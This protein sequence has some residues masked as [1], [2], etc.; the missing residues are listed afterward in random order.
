MKKYKIITLLL[1]L[2]IPIIINAKTCERSSINIDSIELVNKTINVVEKSEPEIN[3]ETIKLDLEMYK[4]GDEAEYQIR[5]KNTSDADYILDNDSISINSD[6]IDYQFETSDK[7]N[8]IESKET[9]NATLKIIYKKEIPDELAATGHYNDNKTMLIGLSSGKEEQTIINPITGS[10]IVI[11]IL[12]LALASELAIIAINNHKQTKLLLLVIGLLLIPVSIKAFCKLD[13]EVESN[14]NLIKTYTFK[15]EER[16]YEFL[17]GMT[18]D[19][20]LNSTYSEGSFLTRSNVS[21]LTENYSTG[22]ITEEYYEDGN[23]YITN[24]KTRRWA[25]PGFGIGG[26]LYLTEANAG[27]V[28][29]TSL[30]KKNQNYTFK[31]YGAVC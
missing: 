27:I 14:V 19:D 6:Y 12:V 1:I 24:G 25:C 23:Y 16:T 5:I 4:V 8:I 2:F 9:K 26:Y 11:L 31:Y 22:K 30:V 21:E 13:L 18:F 29:T 10:K 3:D 7:T 17:P 28:P 15:I 20:W